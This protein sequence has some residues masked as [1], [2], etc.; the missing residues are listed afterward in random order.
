MNET[1]A[2]P[3]DNYCVKVHH[4]IGTHDTRTCLTR[5]KRK[6]IFGVEM[7]LVVI[8]D[9]NCN[10]KIVFRFIPILSQHRHVELDPAALVLGDGRGA[11]YNLLENRRFSC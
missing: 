7:L 5:L 3:I 2:R 10:T 8:V 6:M 9:V 1:V 11:D 4:V